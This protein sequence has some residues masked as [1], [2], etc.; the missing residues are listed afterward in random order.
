MERQKT[1]SVPR[2]LLF[3]L[4][5]WGAIEERGEAELWG[6]AVKR[7]CRWWLNGLRCC[8]KGINQA[9]SPRWQLLIQ[10][11]KSDVPVQRGSVNSF[12]A[13]IHRGEGR[14]TWAALVA[15]PG[16]EEQR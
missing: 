6:C 12:G 10:Q 8:I 7:F 4:P 15:L 1:P 2:A 5:E 11:E 9:L 14:S 3:V 13:V 16:S